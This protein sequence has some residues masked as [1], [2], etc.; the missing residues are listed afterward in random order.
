[1]FSIVLASLVTALYIYVFMHVS[2][3]PWVKKC[4]PLKARSA[5]FIALWAMFLI[6]LM[7]G[8]GRT[9][10]LAIA[11]EFVGMNL[12]GAIM[13]ITA[14]LMFVDFITVFGLLIRKSAPRLRAS[15][16]IVG[17]ALSV[18]ALFQG[19]SPPVVHKYDVYLSGLPGEMDG[20]VIVGM[21]DMHLGSLI[22]ERWLR[23]VVSRV[24]SI[25]PDMIVL[26]GDIFE[27]HE[28]PQDN[29][30]PLFHEL[31][32]P[33][34]VW[35]VPGN[36]ESRRGDDSFIRFINDN[37]IKVLVNAWAEPAPD[38]YLAGTGNPSGHHRTG[39]GGKSIRES[40]KGRPEGGAT[41]LLSHNADE[42]EVASQS[43]VG[44]MLSGHTHGGQIWPYT[45]LVKRTYPLLEGMH[46]INGM[47]VIVCRGTGTWG[48]RMR[49]WKR[50][51]ILHI[52]LH[53]KPEG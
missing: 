21:S 31:T 52:T 27:G 18:I 47:T 36:H 26:L 43:G 37:G 46:K 51:E 20:K 41:I 38:F 4:L 19:M 53:K 8:H 33:L 6:G 10:P 42:P 34:G 40:L 39:D 50:G 30:M 28:P 23:E 44:L 29:L 11:L 24:R 5:L 35:A 7:Y 13:L 48:P 15:A 17:L 2:S 22:G 14:S 45:Y 9:G 12:M 32:A 16:V 1:L 25:R 3:V 49:L